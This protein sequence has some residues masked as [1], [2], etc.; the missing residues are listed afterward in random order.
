MNRALQL[1][2][3]RYNALRNQT[4]S[5]SGPGDLYTS[6]IPILL[7]DEMKERIQSSHAK[8]V[9]V[10]NLMTKSGQ[11][12]SYTA[13][14]HIKDLEHYLGKKPDHIIINNGKIPEDIIQWY[15]TIT[16]SR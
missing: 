11:T 1:I 13:M 4:S 3:M 9:Y 2:R 14:D 15:T 7:V 5:S 10:M 16:K 8:I 12:S 6:I